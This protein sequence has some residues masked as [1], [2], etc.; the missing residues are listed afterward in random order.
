MENTNNFIGNQKG[1]LSIEFAAVFCLFILLMMMIYDIYS[2]I[3]LQ[4]KLER[5]N[6]TAASLFRERSALYPVIDDQYNAEDLSLCRNNSGSCFLTYELFDKAQVNQLKDLAS[7]LLNRPVEVTIDAL[8]ILQDKNSPGNL[9]NAQLVSLNQ[10]T[11]TS[12]NCSDKASLSGYFG[13]LPSMDDLQNDYAK[14]VPYVSR[15]SGG[16]WIPLYR[17]SMCVINEESFYLKWL[18]SD[19]K[20]SQYLPNLC[21]NVVVLSRC[22]DIQNPNENCPIYY[23]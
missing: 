15:L 17:V 1:A 3:T 23:Q 21:S 10:N 2:S 5:V 11:C 22:N 12:A 18:N 9:A 19:R 6:Y 7:F 13:S 8:F 14:L 4:S 16:R 20:T